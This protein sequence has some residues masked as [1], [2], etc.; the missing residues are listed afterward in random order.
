[1]LHPPPSSPGLM[2]NCA[3]GPGDPVRRDLSFPSLTPRNTGSSAGACLRARIR[4]TRWRT[5]TN[6]GNPATRRAR[7]L[8]IHFAPKTRGRREDRVRAA[9]AVSCAKMHL[10]KR[11]RAYR[12]S[13]GNPAFPAR[14]FYSLFRALPGETGLCLSPSSPRSLLLKN[15]TP[16]TGASGPHDFAVRISRARQSQPS[17]PPLPAP[18]SVTMANAP[19]SGRDGEEYAGDLRPT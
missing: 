6:I 17:R 4:A 7:V 8:Q 10:A 13:G 14:W 3:R 18:T 11:T 15:L 9:P 12:F 16:A 19:L 2:R 5:M 1:M